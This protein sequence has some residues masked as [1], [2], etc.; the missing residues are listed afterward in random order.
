MNI[1]TIDAIQNARRALEKSHSV[2]KIL[3]EQIEDPRGAARSRLLAEV[4]LDYIAEAEEH[5][6][7]IE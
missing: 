6:S 7:E 5:L 3:I 2:A 1:D 4:M